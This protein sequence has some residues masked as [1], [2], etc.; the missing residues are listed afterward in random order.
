MYIYINTI[1]RKEV[2]EVCTQTVNNLYEDINME[3]LEQ[4]HLLT[5]IQ[6]SSPCPEATSAPCEYTFDIS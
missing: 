5:N 6:I 4:H 3:I 2:N 1:Y